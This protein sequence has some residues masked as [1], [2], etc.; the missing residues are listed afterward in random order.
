[1]KKCTILKPL[2]TAKENKLLID[3]DIV[4]ILEQ[5]RTNSCGNKYI[6]RKIYSQT[7]RDYLGD[8]IDESNIKVEKDWD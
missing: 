3:G 8:L 6:E 5:V 4:F 7:T 2:V 1:V